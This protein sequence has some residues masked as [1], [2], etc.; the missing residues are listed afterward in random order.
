MDE[1]LALV[2]VVARSL[3]RRSARGALAP[4]ASLPAL[5][6]QELRK[7]LVD[8]EV[9]PPAALPSPAPVL[10]IAPSRRPARSRAPGAP[11][12]PPPPLS[13]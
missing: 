13:Y 3:A 9:A 8:E 1:A 11:P 10:P 4:G 2:T 6:A 7:L 12:K 5:A